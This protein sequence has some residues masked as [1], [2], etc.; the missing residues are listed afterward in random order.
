MGSTT[1]SVIAEASA[2]DHD[3]YSLDG[4]S[5]AESEAERQG[6]EWVE[7]EGG[8]MA[9]D[10]APL[11]GRVLLVLSGAVEHALLPSSGQGQAGEMV[12][13]RAWCC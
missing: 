8:E 5:V 4:I 11:S 1:S 12:Y 7:C 2:P 10:I 13:V 3:T 6:F 9:L